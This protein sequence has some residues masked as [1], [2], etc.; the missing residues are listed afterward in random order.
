MRIVNRVL[1][2]LIGVLLV[3]AG[4]AVV[5]AALDLPA[6]WGIPLP[7][8]WSP[9]APDDVLLTDADRTRW[10]G[11]GWWWPV[12]IG[13]LSLLVL[14]T[15][16][17]A[18]TQFRRGRRRELPLGDEA[19]GADATV[20]R[21]AALE[22]VVTEEIESFPGVERARVVLDGGRRGSRLRAGVVLEAGARPGEVVRRFRTEALEHLRTSTG[23]ERLPAD[24]RVRS[25][26]HA[27]D[28]VE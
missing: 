17:W 27:A 8:G 5:A 11:E 6:R 4:A 19:E 24:L 1:L 18:L 25:T 20:L 12:V 23:R 9:R 10:V 16:W 2:A 22:E 21:G 7:D 14:L 3:G 26:R 13:V 15:A 28:R